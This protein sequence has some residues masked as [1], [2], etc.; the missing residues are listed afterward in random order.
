M[1]KIDG[2]GGRIIRKLLDGSRPQ[3]RTSTLGHIYK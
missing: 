1:A 2:W 3:T